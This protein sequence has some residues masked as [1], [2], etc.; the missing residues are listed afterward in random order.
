M[1]GKKV[2]VLRG[3]QERNLFASRQLMSLINQSK[4]TPNALYIVTVV[5]RVGGVQKRLIRGQG[6][7]VRDETALVIAYYTLVLD[8]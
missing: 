4:R 6:R 7:V 3:F 2:I 8:R 5:V 1:G